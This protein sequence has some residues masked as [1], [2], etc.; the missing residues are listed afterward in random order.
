M[1]FE[2]SGNL[3]STEY[4]TRV[5]QGLKLNVKEVKRLSEMTQE[6]RAGD[7]IVQLPLA[8]GQLLFLFLQWS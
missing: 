7:H 4:G 1:Q 5:A 8:W 3:S 6:E 2:I